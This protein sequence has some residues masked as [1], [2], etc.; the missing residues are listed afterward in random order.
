MPL[1]V[2]CGKPSSRT[3]AASH[4]KARSRLPRTGCSR[5]LGS[6]RD[7]SHL[8]TPSRC[9]QRL[10]RRISAWSPDPHRDRRRSRAIDPPRDE[11]RASEEYG[12]TGIQVFRTTLLAIATAFGALGIFFLSYSGMSAP[13]GDYA[14]V[15]LAMAS[16][17]AWFVEKSAEGN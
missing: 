5:P 14:V 7:R 11:S 16:A 2:C 17:I 1:S 15:Y 4:A 12:M 6:R 10:S 9:G 13:V 3:E 8:E